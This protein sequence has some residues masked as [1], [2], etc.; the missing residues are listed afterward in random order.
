MPNPDTVGKPGFHP[1][2]LALA[3][4][5]KAQIVAQSTQG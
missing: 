1:Q 3:Q 4:L 2:A 5:P